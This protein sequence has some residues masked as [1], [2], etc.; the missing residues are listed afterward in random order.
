MPAPPPAGVLASRGRPPAAPGGAGGA[1]PR[2][3]TAME[4]GRLT[5]RAHPFACAPL[6][7]AEMPDDLRE[8][9]ASASLTVM[10]GDLNYRRLVGDRMW[11]AS[12]PFAAVTGYFPGPVV[13]LRTLKSDALAGVPERTLAEL[14]APGRPWRTTGTHAMVQARP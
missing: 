3:W 7:Y 5:L 10:K 4:E 12:T 9:F 11:A 1:A 8:E 13:A 14:D 2:L 6:P